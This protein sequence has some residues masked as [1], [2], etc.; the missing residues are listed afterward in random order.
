MN[1]RLNAFS[2]LLLA[3]APVA[4]FAMQ[5]C[6]SSDEAPTPPPDGDAEASAV[7]AGTIVDAGQTPENGDAD[8]E[9][10]ATLPPPTYDFAITCTAT[11]CVE[12]IA[13]RGGSHACVILQDR[14]T[15][16]WGS[17]DSG[18]LG[19]G[20]N[21]AGAMPPFATAPRTVTEVTNAMSLA[22]AG[23]GLSGTTCVLSREGDV[24]CFGSGR[25][26]STRPRRRRH[27]HPSSRSRRRRRAQR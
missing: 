8:A 21:D 15:R 6:S 23:S 24:S 3:L 1:A 2:A 12:Q 27:H 7:E 5:A 16:C 14:S 22:L 17:N 26:G 20:S 10:D 11:P 4:S 18:Q 9:A 19:T 13:A 25:I